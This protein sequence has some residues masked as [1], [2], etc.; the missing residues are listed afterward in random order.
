MFATC[1]NIGV[2]LRE[3]RH[4]VDV[5]VVLVPVFQE[6]KYGV[7]EKKKDEAED[8]DLFTTDQKF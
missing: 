1:F 2:F 4:V 3:V 6:G 7:D 5:P 8:E